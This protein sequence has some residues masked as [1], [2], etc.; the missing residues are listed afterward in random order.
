LVEMIEIDYWVQLSLGNGL[1]IERV[2]LPKTVQEDIDGVANVIPGNLI[3]VIIA[4]TA[5]GAL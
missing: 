5:R 4:D 2:Y 3:G 1:R